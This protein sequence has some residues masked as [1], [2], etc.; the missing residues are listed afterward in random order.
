M[1][2][3][4]DIKLPPE[5]AADMT[6]VVKRAAE[7]LKIS[8]RSVEA[9]RIVRRAVDARKSPV[10]IDMGLL[11]FTCGEEIPERRVRE[12]RARR[13]EISP[14]VIVAGSGPAGLFASLR[15]I[16]RGLRPV[17][18]ERGNELKRRKRDI[19]AISRHH[20][21]NPDSNYCF[22]EG[23]AGT[24][25]DGKLYTRSKKRGDNSAVL[26]LL[27]RFG[28]DEKILYDTHAHI[29]T[30]RLPAIIAAIRDAITDCGGVL[31][32]G[33]RITDI[34]VK[35]GHV[36]GVKAGEELF[37]SD[38][39]ILATGHSARDIYTVISD[40]GVVMEA[41]PFAAGVRVEHPQ[42]LIDNIQYHGRGRGEYLPAATYKLVRQFG[43]RGVYS[44]CMCPGGFIV[45]SATS[46]GEVVV[47]GMSPSHRGSVWANSGIVTEVRP[48]D[49][50]QYGSFGALAGVEFQR[51]LEHMAWREGGRR[52]TAPAQRITD[53]IG[54]RGSSSLPSCS[55]FPGV[56]TSP[57]HEWLPDFIVE[58][59]AAG[60]SG[61]GRSLKGFVTRDALIAGVE[62]RT[63]SPV[64]VLRDK[65]SLQS[66]SVGG[67]YP[68]GEGSGYAGGILSTA[69]D[70]MRVA[71]A[72]A[73][74]YGLTE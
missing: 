2:L 13:V 54:R 63:S 29:G 59:L 56:T 43:G 45:P 62:T 17:I 69:V 46:D 6:L 3:K 12:F 73:D 8:D 74:R 18:I 64:R 15:L 27:T 72:I 26:E 22:G 19:A 1:P 35:G 57:L 67:L 14:E 20:V 7:R 25:S 68:C 50:A 38:R 61:F 28:A 24:F 21:V 9:V 52:Q 40:R 49:M 60:L 51:E 53:F 58:A 4:I 65:L 71:D 66:L 39:V 10:K 55:Y 41:K 5:E 42:Q 30:D 34:V 16:E 36:K 44:F 48:E 11:L 31:L 70:G 23:G 47:N 37:S 33:R 32:T